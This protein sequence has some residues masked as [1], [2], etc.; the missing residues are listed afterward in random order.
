[1]RILSCHIEN[2]GKLKDYT[3]EFTSELN[4]F[5]CENGWGKSTLA[6]FLR[7]MFYKFEGEHKR[8]GKERVT[9]RPWQ[10]GVYGGTV[11]FEVKGKRYSMTRTFGN[12]DAED[13]FELR[14][15]DT[16]LESLDYT[17][18]IGKEIFEI[19]SEAFMRTAF[20]GQNDC[21]TW[22][23][24]EINA[25]IGNLSFD[26]EDVNRYEEACEKLKGF[27]NRNSPKKKTGLL[28]KKR[29][30][31]AQLE[32]AIRSEDS[33]KTAIIQIQGQMDKKREEM[34]VLKE[35]QEDIVKKQRICSK[36][37]ELS[38][39]RERYRDI[40]KRCKKA[41]EEWSEIRAFFGQR[42]PTQKELDDVMTLYVEMKSNESSVNAYKMSEEEEDR[43]SFYEVKF[44]EHL[45]LKE[46]FADFKKKYEQLQQRRE[47]R[48]A[49][50]LRKEEREKLREY[51]DKFGSS[52]ELLQILSQLHGDWIERNRKSDILSLKQYELEQNI[53]MEAEK[54]RRGKERKGFF[55]ILLGLIIL[56]IGTFVVLS[57]PFLGA[58]LALAGIVCILWGI[59]QRKLSSDLSEGVKSESTVKIEEEMRQDQNQIGKIEGKMEQYFTIW[60]IPFEET[61]VL[62][63]LNQFMQE[64]IQYDNLQK[65]EEQASLN[66]NQMNIEGLREELCV[67][68]SKYH[69]PYEEDA[70]LEY[71]NI[72]EKEVLDY[73]RLDE[74]RRNYISCRA[75]YIEKQQ[76]IE[77][78]L[79]S[80][81]F[82][83]E[84]NLENQIRSLKD[85]LIR[86]QQTSGIVEEEERARTCFERENDVSQLEWDVLLEEGENLVT[87]NDAYQRLNKEL[88]RLSA[89]LQFYRNQ[90]D[91]KL[92]ELDEIDMKR[93]QLEVLNKEF[94]EQMNQ[95]ELMVKTQSCLIEAKEA[96]TARYVDPLMNSYKKYHQK[97]VGEGM[98][99]YHMDANAQVTI[100]EMGMQRKIE[101]FSAGYRDLTGLCLRFAFMEAM[102]QEEKPFIVLDD[103]FVNLDDE[104]VEAGK[105]LIRYLAEEYQI[106][107]FTCHES[108]G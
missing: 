35:Q 67:F 63:Y 3:I 38:T 73:Q 57:V 90:M 59:S 95:Y 39:L 8:S 36:Q 52:K 22:A 31:K 105:K 25:K 17:T 13:T 84:E 48:N 86:L 9:F 100:E 10:G 54:N 50:C 81:G 94:D 51:Q 2:F 65:K 92:E 82:V 99:A 103:P 5:C 45:P 68:L 11:H 83:L 58:F 16:N 61:L 89:E 14:N 15:L 91:V 27:L 1:M 78:Y 21:V 70:L 49:N 23:N 33:I 107:Y 76:D 72:L 4:T 34:A 19:N 88:D 85:M 93:E 96:L 42:I 44:K 37:K 74:K 26:T 28:Y 66:Q 56:V 60:G 75:K 77:T 97:L 79:D 106:I 80:L 69:M 104:K 98:D 6:A 30:E 29:D 32:V 71:E 102:Y 55:F 47:E 46:E 7:V 64:A 24:G 43:W 62:P 101:T 108:R 41:N 18:N 87:L 53:T 40:K 20:I 12:K